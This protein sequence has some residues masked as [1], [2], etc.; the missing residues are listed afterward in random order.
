MIITVIILLLLL[1]LIDLNYI[2]GNRENIYFNVVHK[3]YNITSHTEQIT[4]NEREQTDTNSNFVK[5]LK[6]EKYSC[7]HKY[8]LESEAFLLEDIHKLEKQPT[9][10]KTIFFIISSCFKDNLMEIQKR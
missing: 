3:N 5:L 8:N 2:W 6:T 10:D 7:Y 9:P 1:Y 4:K